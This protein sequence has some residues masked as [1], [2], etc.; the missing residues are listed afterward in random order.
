MNPGLY[1]TET[2][3]VSGVNFCNASDGWGVY[4]IGAFR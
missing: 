2:M 3:L 4:F 1:C